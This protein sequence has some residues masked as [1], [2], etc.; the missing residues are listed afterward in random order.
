MSISAAGWLGPVCSFP[1]SFLFPHSG[2]RQRLGS[3][4]P[5]SP[6][7]IK[8]EPGLD[9][10]LLGSRGVEPR[11]AQA[12]VG[13][14]SARWLAGICADV[15]KTAPRYTNV[16]PRAIVIEVPRRGTST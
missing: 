8:E 13:G 3:M 4:D 9:F 2:L 14:W 12:H 7:W 1:S 5:R 15:Y 6:G 11:Q 10:R 16:E